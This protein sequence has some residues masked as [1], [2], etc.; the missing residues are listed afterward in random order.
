MDININVNNGQKGTNVSDPN[1]ETD[2]TATD[3][4][5]STFDSEMENVA[6]NPENLGGIDAGTPPDW[7]LQSIAGQ[8]DG[9]E[10][11]TDEGE[12]GGASI[13]DSEGD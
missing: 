10:E 1:I 7:L 12:D 9:S 13:L 6:E 11:H 2:E 5:A 3:A 4:G 8:E